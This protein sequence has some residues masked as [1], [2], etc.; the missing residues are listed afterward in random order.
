MSNSLEST[1]NNKADQQT[2]QERLQKA[3]ELFGF[4]QPRAEPAP[5]DEEYGLFSAGDHASE[6]FRRVPKPSY[7]LQEQVAGVLLKAQEGVYPEQAKKALCSH[8]GLDPEQIA[9]ELPQ[10]EIDKLLLPLICRD[11]PDSWDI[12]DVASGEVQRMRRDFL[13]DT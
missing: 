2:F 1:D 13:L 3:S 5:P 12:G 4:M 9:D 8:N 11:L 7:R 10:K 6:V